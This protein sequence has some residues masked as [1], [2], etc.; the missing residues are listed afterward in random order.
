[1]LGA[2]D[3]ITTSSVMKNGHGPWQ[4]GQPTGKVHSP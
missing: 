3:N 4:P 1:M 2:D